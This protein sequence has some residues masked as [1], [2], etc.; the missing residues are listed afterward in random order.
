MVRMLAFIALLGGLS[1]CSREPKTYRVTGTVLW[2]GTPMPSGQINMV[3]VDGQTHP[4]TS[5]ITDGKFEL[6]IT[7][8]TKRVEIYGQRS[9][10]YDKVMKQ[11]TF[12][13]Y[14][15]PEFNAKS[16]LQFE[17]EP[18]DNNN[19]VVSLPPKN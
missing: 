10:G 8:G 18:H 9:K 12:E 6:R 16:I 11:E 2:N 1:G 19:Y 5:K 4:A 13:N 15:G 17:V 14:T 7:A 3:A